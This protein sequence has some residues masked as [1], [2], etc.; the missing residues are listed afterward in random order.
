MRRGMRSSVAAVVA[1][2]VVL[3][4]AGTAIAATRYVTKSGSDSTDC[5]NSAAPCLTVSYAV[6]QAGNGDTI[7]IG[8]GT[9]EEAV[10][11]E[12]ALAFV[13]TGGGS[14]PNVG[15][16]TVIRGP[17]GGLGEFG[18]T[19][20][21]LHGGGSVRSLRAIGGQGGN[22]GSF[23]ELGGT[24]IRYESI[25][26]AP[27]SLTLQDVVA[28]GGAGGP[29]STIQGPGG[30][31]IDARGGPGPVVVTATGSD[32]AGG[33]GF[34]TG[35]AISV[36]GPMATATVSDARVANDDLFGT[37][38]AV[39]SDASLTLESVDARSN[40]QV[41]A[42]YD[43]ALTIRRSRLHSGGTTVYLAPGSQESPE[44]D[45][46]DSLL[47]SEEAEALSVES[48][49]ESPATARVLGSTLIGRGLQAVLAKREAGEGPA[50]V[51]LRN[52]IARHYPPLEIIP[53]ADLHADGGTI[54]ADFSSFTT[55]LEENGGTV[56]AP[57]SGANVAGDPQFV[58]PANEV[59]ILQNTSPLIDRGDAGIVQ[60]GELDLVGSPRSL[61]GNRDCLAAPDLGAFEVTGQEAVCPVDLPP[62]ISA[63]GMTHRVFAPKGKPKASASGATT[64]ARK[65]K[66]G[67][68]F[69]YTLSEPSRIVIR[70]DRKAPGRRVGKGA[71]SR[72]AKV[73]AANRDRKPCTRF[74]KTTSLG[75]QKQGGRQSTPW[76]GRVRNKPAKPGRYR[77][78][79]VATDTA[80][81]KSQPHSLGFR[82]VTG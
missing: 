76:S 22:G 23:G 28:I 33:A 36:D 10:S 5:T 53:A 56:T 30:R 57:G 24:G 66:R 25:S 64:S 12:K 55:R 31:G 46:I 29:G 47:V 62:T 54:V 20:L 80:G 67:T 59:F 41:A 69:T 14:L 70:I 26:A 65:I 42:L 8:A 74:V 63:F 49:E 82:I 3:G 81:Q 38:I 6:L 21:E 39:F 52:S 45:V 51:I 71:K 78:T 2:F 18:K 9:F 60:P 7:Q 48:E 77:A 11:T 73:T 37:A 43:G 75:A 72:C 79:I 32:F 15:A 68:R 50:T 1:V 58:D 27:T 4:T 44:L 13:G 61:D 40:G 34:G 35:A 17:A 19:A 16:T